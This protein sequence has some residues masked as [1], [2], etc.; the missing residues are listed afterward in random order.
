M[1]GI[2]PIIIMP[3]NCD[4]L[5]SLLSSGLIFI[6][7]SISY[8]LLIF[9]ENE[10][11]DNIIPEKIRMNGII[12]RGLLLMANGKNRKIPT[13]TIPSI[14]NTINITKPDNNNNIPA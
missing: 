7:F 2:G 10:I 14:A 6:L 3:L 5:F 13:L 11:N 12:A 8:L 9:P 1:I 4:L